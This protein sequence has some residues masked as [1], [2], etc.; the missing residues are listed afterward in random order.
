M[1]CKI[2]KK[3]DFPCFCE[4]SLNP[5][6]NDCFCIHEETKEDHEFIDLSERYKEIL[7]KTNKEKIEKNYKLEKFLN[8]TKLSPKTWKKIKIIN[9]QLESAFGIFLEGHSD[10]VNSLIVTSD[11]KYI[12]SGS[13]D[14]T[15]RIWN[16]LEKRQE[17][18]LKGH[19]SEVNSIA[20]TSDNKY[21]VS[22]SCNNSISVWNLLEK[23]PASL[24][25]GHTS[26][27]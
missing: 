20:V 4:D 22:C 1:L 2:N 16:L 23:K 5:R 14:K 9:H 3:P 26:S 13:S 12:I 21:V 17:R 15:I 24:L 27:V 11:N 6:T 19:K 18:V 10:S 8:E 7:L 25:Q